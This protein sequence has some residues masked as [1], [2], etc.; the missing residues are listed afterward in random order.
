MARKGRRGEAASDAL[1]PRQRCCQ[2]PEFRFYFCRI[3]D[4][5]RDLLPEEVAIAFAEPVDRDLECAFRCAHLASQRGI[6]RLG[7]VEKEDLQPVEMIQASMLDEL[8]AKSIDDSIEQRKRPAPVEDP[9]WRLV[10]RRLALITLLA[11]R[12]FEG[13]DGSAAAFLRAIPIAFVG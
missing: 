8:G 11:G 3:G 10:V 9:L 4:R 6:R 12:D 5:L 7:L 2:I 13:Q 1:S